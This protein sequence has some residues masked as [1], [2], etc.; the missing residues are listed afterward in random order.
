MSRRDYLLFALFLLGVLLIHWPSH[1]AGFV[2]DFLGWQAAYE[3]GS[4]L[5]IF[6]FFGYG[7]HQQVLQFVNYTMYRL[8]G[9]AG[10]PWYLLF[11]IFHAAN[12]FL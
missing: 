5:G 7:G 12:G 1:E 9:T 3:K 10:L 4:W 11:C 8:F 2:S 6:N